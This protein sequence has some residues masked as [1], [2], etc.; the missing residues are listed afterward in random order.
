MPCNLL[1]VID[2]SGYC[3]DG[4]EIFDDDI[5]EDIYTGKP[6][7]IKCQTSKLI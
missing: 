4:R 1:F 6:V 3:E 5:E 2:G 7:L